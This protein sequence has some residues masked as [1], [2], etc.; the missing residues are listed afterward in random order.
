MVWKGVEGRRRREVAPET[1]LVVASGRGPPGRVWKAV[2]G[3]G[4]REIAPESVLVVT[5]GRAGGEVGRADGN[6]CNGHACNMGDVMWRGGGHTRW[7]SREV[8]VT[9]GGGWRHAPAPRGHEMAVE[10]NARAWKAGARTCRCTARPSNLA[11]MSFCNGLVESSEGSPANGSMR[12]AQT[13]VDLV[14][15]HIA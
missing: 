8:A 6:L 3:N 7:R 14:L 9:R 5:S 4:R 2:E 10:G 1:A 15:S 13:S 12:A 11:A